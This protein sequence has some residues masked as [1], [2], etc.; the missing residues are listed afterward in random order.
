VKAALVLAL[1]ACSTAASA[2]LERSPEAARLPPVEHVGPAPPSLPASPRLACVTA[3]FR[4]R[5]GTFVDLGD[6]PARLRAPALFAELEP[7]RHKPK[8]KAQLAPERGDVVRATLR[9]DRVDIVAGERAHAFAAP[10][11]A[12]G[13]LGVRSWRGDARIVEV[14]YACGCSVLALAP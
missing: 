14:R 3:A 1:A 8:R 13:V 5:E 7:T 6:G 2:D 9:G 4:D 10:S 12:T 11:C